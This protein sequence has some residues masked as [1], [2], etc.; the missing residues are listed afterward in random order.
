M[1]T[2]DDNVLS[3]CAQ[4]MRAASVIESLPVRSGCVEIPAPLRDVLV[5]QM[6]TFA[7]LVDQLSLMIGAK[8]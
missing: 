6:R 2:R 3:A 4:M 1:T 7:Q 5:A 8:P